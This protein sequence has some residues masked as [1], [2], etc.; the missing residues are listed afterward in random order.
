MVG[1][2][3]LTLG[4]VDD[5]LTEEAVSIEEPDPRESEPEIARRLQMIASEDAEAP[6]VLRQGLRDAELGGEIRH[7]R[8]R[9]A[10]D[11]RAQ[12]RDGLGEVGQRH[13]VVGEGGEIVIAQ[14]IDD[15]EGM[16]AR[17]RRGEPV[18]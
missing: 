6:R 18:E 7:V 9:R 12:R 15:S 5:L 17:G 3:T 10:G 11:P 2:D 4:A 1:L 16:L 8:C 14:A 13:L